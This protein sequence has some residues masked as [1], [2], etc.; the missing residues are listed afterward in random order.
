MIP[1]QIKIQSKPNVHKTTTK[2][3]KFDEFDFAKRILVTDR[4]GIIKKYMRT[5]HADKSHYFDVWH[6]VIIPE[7]SVAFFS[8]KFSL[9]DVRSGL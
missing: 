2:K 9:V 1:S 4:H 3:S 5:E 8:A 7:Q 6:L